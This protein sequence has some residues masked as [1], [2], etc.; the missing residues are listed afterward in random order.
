MKMSIRNKLIGGFA[1]VISLLIVISVVGIVNINSV[2]NDYQEKVLQAKHVELKAGE[3]QELIYKALHDEAEFLAVKDVKIADEVRSGLKD[4][5]EIATTLLNTE[6]DQKILDGINVATTNMAAYKEKFESLVV[7]N[8]QRGLTENDGIQ[9]DF[10]TAA[11]EFASAVKSN[12]VSGG[13][14]L[15][16]TARKHEKDYML[17]S[18]LKY[19]EKFD[20]T[21][22]HLKKN[23]KMS[24]LSGNSKNTFLNLLDKYSSGFHSLVEKD[25]EIKSSIQSLKAYSE[26]GIVAAENILKISAQ[27]GQAM[28]AA[29]E[30][31]AAG[32]VT[33]VWIFGFIA[34]IVGIAIAIVLTRQIIGPL[35]KVVK[36]AQ[37]IS[38]GD[39]SS[40]IDVDQN[41]ELGQLAEEF[42]KMTISL[43]KKAQI[44]T[45]IADE[46]FDEEVEVLSTEDELGN[47]MQRMRSNLIQSKEEVNAA[48]NDATIKVNYLN[49]LPT[50]IHV[51]DKNMTV[52]YINPAAADV[53]GESVEKCL[54]KKCH[55][56][57]KNAHCNT[58]LCATARAM[59]EGKSFTAET[60]LDKQNLDI[61]YYGAPIRD[62]DGNIIGA[63]EQATDISDMKA[64]MNEINCTAEA[65]EAG[66]LQKRAA[67]GNAQGDYLTLI[68]TFNRAI[69]NIL[70]PINEAVAVL[71]KMA[72]GD[73]TNNVN[74]DYQGDHAI[75]KEAMN[76]TLYAL[77]DIL[78]Q[79]A[80]SV[81]QIRNGA[82][83][84]SDSSQSLSQGATEQ[85]S[86][87]EETSASMAEI[88]SQ[89][90][91]N[92][93]NAQQANKLATVTRSAAEKGNE[94]MNKMLEAMNEINGS[95]N[96]ISKIIKVI[97]EIA[98]QTNLLALNAAVE[99]ARAGA[100]GKGFAVVAEEV[101]NLAQRSAKAAK[102]TTELIEGSVAKVNNG[103]V[104]AGE[105][106]KSLEEI[107]NSISKVTDL[108]GEIASSSD[109]QVTAISE[110]N[111]ALE[112]IDQVTQSST[113]SAEESAAA[114]EELSSQAVQLDGMLRNFKLTRQS[115]AAK[116]TVPVRKELNRDHDFRSEP[117]LEPDREMI[118]LDDD[119]FGKF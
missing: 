22:S 2:I 119:E 12:P 91:T 64:I 61:Q 14:T 11:H 51:V 92:A 97:D 41:D 113:A 54:G 56:L 81:E 32:A 98:F 31:S 59:R 104:Q 86:S 49:S 58:E 85:A 15:Y 18:N 4:F 87:L 76:T 60:K 73:L 46:N 9:G 70:V 5:S 37:A 53:I 10:R 82:Q 101:R 103:T 7:F 111:N 105:T 100:H 55:E 52:Q 79:V 25:S 62:K 16:L 45:M 47:A 108:I 39:L 50:P 6:Q 36:A 63:L 90:K 8:E 43:K 99:A 80:Q 71:E 24:G 102:E 83:Q 117:A 107:I 23:V 89:S 40:E 35:S 19:V 17:R 57:L 33:F 114:S 96:Q 30:E 34:A 68:N 84:V 112:Q 65:L 95:S 44:A 106:A 1:L 109:D 67:A 66:E 115:A 29:I 3:L 21:L 118:A 13:T 74:G 110:I 94:S 93:E 69:D 20:K 38:I 88:G 78:G 42:R 27:R 116:P 26:R 28:E 48:L 72:G 77:N 75:M